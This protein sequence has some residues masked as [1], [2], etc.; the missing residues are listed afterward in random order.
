[1]W[2]LPVLILA[3]VFA[4]AVPIGLFMARVFDGGLRVPGWLKWIEEKVDTGPQSWKQY[5]VAFMLFNI[6][7][8]V[9]GFA[10]LSLQPYLPLNPDGKGM[11]SPSMIFHTTV[12]FMTN[13]NQQHY[14][15][16]VHLSYFSQLFFVC[17]KQMLSP[18][19]GLAALLAIIRGLRG[20]KHM[21][22]FYLDLWRGVTYFFAPLCLVVAVLLMAGGMPM[23]LDGSAKASVVEAGA[24]GNDDN[25]AAKPQEICRGPVAAIVAVK[26]FGTNGGGYFAINSAHPFEN[27]NSWTNFLECVGIILIPVATLVMFG[28]MLNNFRHAGVIFG[29]ML[30]L[31]AATIVW[32]ITLDTARPNPA[33]MGKADLVY[34]QEVP[35]KDA[36]TKSMWVIA[37]SGRGADLTDRDPAR[38]DADKPT[39]TQLPG[40]PV[41]QELGNL[42]GKE[43]RFGTSAGATWAALTTNTSNGSVNCMHDS[44]NPLAGIT[45]LTG[46]WL[47]CIWGGVGVGLI[48][49]LVYLIIGVFLAGLMVG[50]TPEYLGKK[51]EA[52]EM[53]LASLAMLAHP[54]LI[55]IPTGL[56][57]ATD[58]GMKSMNSPA[59]HGF[60]EVLYEFSSASANNGSGFEGLGDTYGFNATPPLYP[61]GTQWDI[62]CGLVMLFGRF[63]PIIAPIAFAGS[64]A[65]K[66][67]TPYTVGTL[68]T[69]TVTFGF[70]LL[71]TIL[72]VGSLLFLPAAVLGPVAEHLGPLPFGG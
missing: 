34:P 12:S 47:N 15:G 57:V 40:L 21:G 8:F 11:L 9:F 55:L 18:I 52:R 59:A 26:Q 42:E 19:I 45:P 35:Q 62:A 69:D 72:L 71:G 20:D 63:I 41:D 37:H 60:S 61:Y 68:R 4:L 46:M 54:L 10:V 31:S 28:K 65:A 13:T 43:L 23:T 2:T 25:G 36:A 1:M 56:F 70:V 30:V 14:S 7:T 33:L 64:L 67:A 24:M 29:V 58:W 3:L 16:E 27:P 51:V 39:A 17:W 66:R 48:N 50:R 38:N 6:V 49:L 22:N 32:V 5:C 53:K 44:L